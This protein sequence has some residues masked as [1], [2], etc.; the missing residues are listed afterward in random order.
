MGAVTEMRGPTD[1]REG[2]L[3]GGTPEEAHGGS[4]GG[5]AG[6]TRGERREGGREE[7]R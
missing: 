1:L 3:A 2:T 5:R 7:E 4:D 6:E